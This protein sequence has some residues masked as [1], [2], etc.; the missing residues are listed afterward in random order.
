MDKFLFSAD[1]A[2]TRRTLILIVFLYSVL[3]VIG[4]PFRT[5]GGYSA[6]WLM[7]LYCVGFLA[8][9]CRLFERWSSFM[10]I[11]LRGG[12]ILVTWLCKICADLG[13]LISYVSPTILLPGLIMVILFSRLR[14]NPKIIK[15][16]SPLTFGI[17]LFQLN[18][19][20]WNSI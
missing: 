6:L 8:K 1:E 18:T 15:A 7:V 9:R 10:L 2:A 14:P 17:Y 13:C 16:L 11:L 12:C 20:I 5:S 3:G 4:D 19:V